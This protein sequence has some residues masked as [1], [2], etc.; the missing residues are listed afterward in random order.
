M[1][2]IVESEIPGIYPHAKRMMQNVT[3]HRQPSTDMQLHH[4]KK[5]K[6]LFV[7]FFYVRIQGSLRILDKNYT[8]LA[9]AKRTIITLNPTK[10]NIHLKEISVIHFE[11]IQICLYFDRVRIHASQEGKIIIFWY[12][13]NYPLSSVCESYSISEHNATFSFFS[14]SWPRAVWTVS[15][16]LIENNQHEI[17][18]RTSAVQHH[19]PYIT[20]GSSVYTHRPRWEE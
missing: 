20:H 19:F 9:Y 4:M 8:T 12:K 5:P 1:K 13:R 15:H 17:K 7:T 10:I 14:L 16:G 6:T 11:T 3:L 18:V 2:I